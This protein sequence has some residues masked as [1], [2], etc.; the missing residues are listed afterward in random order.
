MACE[1][2]DLGDGSV[3]II[4]GGRRQKRFCSCGRNAPFLSDWK[5]QGKRSRTC[6]RP[7]CAVHGKEVSPGKHL[8]LEHQKAWDAWKRAKYADGVKPEPHGSPAQL[9]LFPGPL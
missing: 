2:V 1:R 7:M 6:D 4:C 9:G 8:C 3:A 5:I